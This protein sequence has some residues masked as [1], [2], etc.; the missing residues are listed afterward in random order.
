MKDCFYKLSK[1][2]L[3]GLQKNHCREKRGDKFLHLGDDQI[4]YEESEG[5]QLA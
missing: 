2:I 3:G 5:S 1:L 4:V